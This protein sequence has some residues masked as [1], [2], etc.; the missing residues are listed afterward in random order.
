MDYDNINDLCDDLQFELKHIHDLS[1]YIV[2]GQCF[3]LKFGTMSKIK[4]LIS[5]MSTRKKDTTFQHSSKYLPPLTLEDFNEFRQGDVIR[6]T[7]VPT[8]STPSPTT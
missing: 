3:A 8:D 4:M 5:W 2:D 6:I 7:K 1:G